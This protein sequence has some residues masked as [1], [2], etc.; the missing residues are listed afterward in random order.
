MEKR[1]RPK[2]E[3][4]QRKEKKVNREDYLT[5]L[6]EKLRGLPEKDIEESLDFYSEMIADRMEE[7]L[8]EEEA[9]ANLPSAAEAAR[10]ILLDKPL[11]QVIKAKQ[12]AKG[13]RSGLQIALLIIGAPLWIPLVISAASVVFSVYVA[14]WSVIISIYAVD[15]GLLAGGFGAAVHAGYF[16]IHGSF[17]VGIFYI[18]LMLVFWGL[19]VLLFFGAK[20]IVGKLLKLTKAFGRWIKSLFVG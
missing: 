9:V 19:S 2:K 6:T 17:G 11:P 16:F 13:K 14:I 7:G 12:S 15:F 5:A 18:G 10:E 8:S 1:A 3:S 4:I 20:W